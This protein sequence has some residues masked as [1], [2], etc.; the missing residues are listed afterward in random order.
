MPQKT[1]ENLSQA[2]WERI[3]RDM[4]RGGNSP[5]PSV[6]VLLPAAILPVSLE[7]DHRRGGVL[8]V[9]AGDAELGGAA[10]GVSVQRERGAAVAVHDDLD[11]LP[12]DRLRQVVARERLVG[13]LLRRE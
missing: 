4:R 12:V 11:V 13:R 6:L 9:G 8:A 10:L 2:H 5:G 1:V 3:Y 7:H